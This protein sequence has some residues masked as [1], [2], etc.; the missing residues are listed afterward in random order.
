MN[1]VPFYGNLEDDMH[2]A[3]AVQRSIIEHF[4]GR[5]V[6]WQYIEKL[7]GFQNSK[8][9]WTVDM[10]TRLAKQGFDIRM[11]EEFD[12]RRFAAEG[13]A[14][15]H[16]HFPPAAAK[17]QLEHSNILELTH[18]DEFLAIV[19]PERRRPTLQDIDG[20]LDEGRLVFTVLNSRELNGKPGYSAHAVLVLEKAG[21]DYIIHDPGLPPHPN[22]RVAKAKLWQAV[23]GEDNTAE[24]T[25]IK[26]HPKPVRADVLLAGMYPEYSRAALAKLFGKGLVRLNSKVLQAGGKVPAG[27]VL[28]ADVSSLSAAAEVADLPIVYEDD[29]CIVINKPAGMLTHAQSAFITEPTVASFLRAKVQGLAG[30]RGG[31]V[32]RLDRATSGVMIAAKN[33]TALSWL[34][35]QFAERKVEKTYVALVHGHMQPTQAVIDMPIERNPKA[36]ATFRVGA[37]G[38]PAQT[39]YKTLKEWDGATLL[40]LRPHTGR[41]HQLRVHLAKLGHPIIGD[42]LY[43]DG[44]YGD[45]LYLHA[46]S[47]RITLPNRGQKTFAAPMPPEFKGQ[48]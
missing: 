7:S 42:P 28:Q 5:K 4:T 45:R 20:M 37:N 29:D 35:R 40:E 8:A 11:I 34:Q 14:Y 30:E 3:V 47:L 15:L 44:E 23:G 48:A 43:G 26:L 24:V 46:A 25:G 13:E 10:W 6:S 12:Y 27:A 39:E 31:I 22:R 9:A 36:P 32:H 41:T 16:E 33:Q 2:C 18:L 1:K 19:K 38:K 21:E 17:W